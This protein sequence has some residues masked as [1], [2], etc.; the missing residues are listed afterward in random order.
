[1]AQPSGKERDTVTLNR[2]PI[3][4]TLPE[5]PFH[6]TWTNI[7]GQPAVNCVDHV[8][9]KSVSYSYSLDALSQKECFNESNFVSILAII[10]W[11]VWHHRCFQYLSLDTKVA[12]HKLMFSIFFKVVLLISDSTETETTPFSHVLYASRLDGAGSVC[13]MITRPLSAS[14]CCRSLHIIVLTIDVMSYC[15]LGTWVWQHVPWT[16]TFLPVLI[17]RHLIRSSFIVPVQIVFTVTQ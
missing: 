4:R 15:I 8:E 14:L 16:A 12:C 5:Y 11:H 3:D 6:V 17:C 9:C 2:V 13:Q 1:M 7:W 10:M